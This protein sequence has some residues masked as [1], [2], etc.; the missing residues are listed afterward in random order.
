MLSDPKRLRT[1][2]GHG[3]LV[4]WKHRL[5]ITTEPA[6]AAIVER[7]L[8][9]SQN[10]A[11]LRSGIGR[12][13]AT[14]DELAEWLVTGLSSGA[15]NLLKTR[16]AAPVFDRPAETDLFD[17]LP[18]E[19][20]R[21]DLD[22][23][24]FDVVDQ[25]GEGLA[26]RYQVHSPSGDPSGLLPAGEQRHVGEL[27]PNADV[28]VELSAI[29]LP[30]SFPSEAEKQPRSPLE[31]KAP[32][33]V[34]DHP[35]ATPRPTGG[36][37]STNAPLP[38]A[39]DDVRCLK[40]VG[41][42]FALNRAFML[43]QA[44]EGARI[45]RHIYDEGSFTEILLVGHTDST[46]SIPRN[47]ELSLERAMS[48]AAFLRDDVEH[49]LGFYDSSVAATRRWGEAE[50]LAMLA[51]LPHD[52]PPYY[53]EGR[54]AFAA[55]EAFQRDHGLAVD[56]KPGDATR[57]ALI[58]QYMA[59]DGTSLPPHVRLTCH[60]CGPAFPAIE[61]EEAEARNRRVEA[62]F[63]AREIQPPAGA[64]TS[65]VP[66][67][68]YPA[69]LESVTA[70]RTFSPTEAGLGSLEIY[71]DAASSEGLSTV[72]YRLRS[73]DAIY[74]STIMLT[75][76]KFES[77]FGVLAFEGLPR[78]SAYTLLVTELDGRETLVFEDVAFDRLDE[79]SEVLDDEATTPLPHKS[80]QEPEDG[81]S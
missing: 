6:A 80:T 47:L 74:D 19:E 17:L 81:R 49:W 14:M 35:P 5:R 39:N 73:T 44:L 46:G 40:L 7:L 62:F 69:W 24:T 25:E 55:V 37:P 72:A 45:L 41:A 15:L 75:D 57:R 76:A 30:L 9:D 16:V 13:E 60:G 61:S 23:L 42:C 31:P 4:S 26:V 70:T 54:R 20:P 65:G 59:A 32:S 36:D 66:E 68:L 21:R 28:E 1:R 34:P 58:R 53:V 8:D 64:D 50:D 71:V 3:Y 79:L 12:P 27:E 38:P 43:P 2:G 11:A 77:E 78:G 18:P 51:S 22:S 52:S 29:V 56:G 33:P 10:V 63:F 67:Q 48:V